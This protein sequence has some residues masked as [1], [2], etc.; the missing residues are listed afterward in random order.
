MKKF[1]DLSIGDL[2]NIS[3]SFNLSQQ[4]VI[5]EI[6]S[7]ENCEI[8]F[9]LDL[10]EED[11]NRLNYLGSIIIDSLF[12]IRFEMLIGFNKEMIADKI[13]DYLQTNQFI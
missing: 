9:R 1:H 7:D 11:E 6:K 4:Y 12:N 5:V 3:E 13:K 8:K 10:K 2:I